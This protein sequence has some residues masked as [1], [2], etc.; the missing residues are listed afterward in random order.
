WMVAATRARSGSER[1]RSRGAREAS[2]GRG[3]VWLVNC[4]L[5]CQYAAG[6]GVDAGAELGSRVR[7]R[8]QVVN[9]RGQVLK[10]SVNVIQRLDPGSG[11]HE[12]NAAQYAPAFLSG[13]QWQPS[14]ALCHAR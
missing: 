9:V 11:K 12:R 7:Y 8:S 5:G 10:S 14:L 13:H 2:Y 1:S 6:A 4:F 3:G